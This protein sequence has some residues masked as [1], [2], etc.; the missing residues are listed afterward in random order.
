[1]KE[2]NNNSVNGMIKFL[3]ALIP[4]AL[5]VAIVW[6]VASIP[7]CHKTDDEKAIETMLAGDEK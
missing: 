4:L 2:E 5:M 7:S 6:A 3:K 1:M